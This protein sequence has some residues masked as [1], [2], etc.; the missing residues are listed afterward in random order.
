MT[1]LLI[2]I[3]DWVQEFRDAEPTLRNDNDLAAML[4][5]GI[6]TG[7]VAR[8][9]VAARATGNAPADVLKP[10]KLLLY[11]GARS[12]VTTRMSLR[13]HTV[14]LGNGK[15][16]EMREMLGR[17]GRPE[18]EVDD[19]E[20]VDGDAEPPVAAGPAWVVPGTPLGV[21]RALFYLE[22]V[23]PGHI[24]DRLKEVAAGG[25]DVRAAADSLEANI[26]TMV[27][28]LLE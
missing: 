9:A 27:Q 8:M 17:P 21:E 18:D 24:Y 28:R 25:G 3:T 20:A 1:E 4:L 10:D 26:E 23:V 14:T 5:D 12:D 13:R 22:N 7:Q 11:S 15:E 16:V 19:D 2:D 6:P